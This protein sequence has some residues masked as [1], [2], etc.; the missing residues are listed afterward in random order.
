RGPADLAGRA[1]QGAGCARLCRLPRC[2]AVRHRRGE[3]EFDRSSGSGQR[4]RAEEARS[5]RARRA[6]GARVAGRL[7][8]RRL[9]GHGPTRE[10]HSDNVVFLRRM[11]GTYARWWAK[12]RLVWVWA[13]VGSDRCS[14]MKRFSPD[15]REVAMWTSRSR[16]PETWKTSRVSGAWSSSVMIDPIVDLPTG[17]IRTEIMPNTYRPSASRSI[18]A[19]KPLMIPRSRRAFSR[20][21][22]VEAAKPTRAARSRL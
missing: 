9:N 8:Y 13:I 21:E 20:P 10:L 14:S 7:R 6:R 5:L 22:H 17:G 2:H 11:S 16:S 1:G 3:A 4:G 15:G 18:S 19:W 12:T